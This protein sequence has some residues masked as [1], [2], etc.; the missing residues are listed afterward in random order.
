MKEPRPGVYVFRLLPKDVPRPPGER[1]PEGLTIENQ[2]AS[3]SLA[4]EEAQGKRAADA[5]LA[6]ERVQ[7]FVESAQARARAS[8]GLVD[9]TWRE[10]ERNIEE[11]FRPTV[12]L[13]ERG[14][15][16]MT[17]QQSVRTHILS[18]TAQVLSSP[19]R[20]APDPPRRGE[21]APRGPAGVPEDSY[22]NG[23]SFEQSMAVLD[24]WQRPAVWRRAE[25]ELIVDGD[26]HV[27]P[28]RVVYTSGSHELDQKAADALGRAA[29]RHS[30]AYI[31]T[32]TRWALEGAYTAN[33][34]ERVGFRFD[35]TGHIPEARGLGRYVTRPLYLMGG[36][37]RSRLSLLSFRKESGSE[38]HTAA[39][40]ASRE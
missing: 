38:T 24:A 17:A 37:L 7:S 36:N 18:V 21:F 1:N 32:V 27:E 16:K 34:P 4:R 23:L 25:I 3:P 39:L 11:R 15:L 20:V 10:L 22:R 14:T 29:R 30:D 35:E 33:P 40:T 2:P 5:R 28:T 26:G 13:T 8:S 9:P 12:A 6:K 19:Y 31:G